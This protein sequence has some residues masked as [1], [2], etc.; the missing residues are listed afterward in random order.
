MAISTFWKGMELIDKMR[1]QFEAQGSKTSL[2]N[3]T[4]W[5]FEAAIQGCMDLYEATQDEKYKELAF[6]FAEKSKAVLVQDAIAESLAQQH[7]QLPDSLRSYEH[8]LKVDITFLENELYQ[9]EKSNK[10][11]KASKARTKLLNKR[12]ELRK[13]GLHLA[14][15]YP[16]YHELKYKKPETNLAAIRQQISDDQAIIEYFVGDEQVY[17]FV[18][19][20]TEFPD[21]SIC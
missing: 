4:W 20:S 11:E 21:S 16:E 13:F 5:A 19:S 14:K 1:Q 3:R 15:E 10:T 18:I 12:D 17:I 6:Q 8:T 7:S 2:A 9:A